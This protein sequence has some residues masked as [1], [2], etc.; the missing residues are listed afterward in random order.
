MNI[1]ILTMNKST[2][3]KT[4]KFLFIHLNKIVQNLLPIVSKCIRIN[5]KIQEIIHI[6]FLTNRIE[7]KTYIC[8]VY[9]I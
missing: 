6:L 7:K 1:S 5:S 2:L 3:V 9:F 8:I 4:F